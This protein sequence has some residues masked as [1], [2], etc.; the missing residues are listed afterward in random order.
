M[1]RTTPPPD[2]AIAPEAV[3]LRLAWETAQAIGR[4][5]PAWPLDQRPVRRS[6]RARRRAR[7]GGG[8]R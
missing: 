4:P 7:R 6:R 5:R 8:R 2:Q 1:S 3:M